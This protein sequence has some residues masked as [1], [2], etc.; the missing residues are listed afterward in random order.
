MKT[1]RKMEYGEKLYKSIKNSFQ[2]IIKATQEKN[3]KLI[4]GQIHLILFNLDSMYQYGLIL[5]EMIITLKEIINNF[6]KLS[7]ED[8]QI[9]K[10]IVLLFLKYELKKQ[11][12]NVKNNNNTRNNKRGG[13]S[14]TFK[15]RK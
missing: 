8:M 7:L 13:R 14:L 1:K 10:E 12:I 2:K 6:E 15:R 3:K 5:K 9:N 11:N 4:T